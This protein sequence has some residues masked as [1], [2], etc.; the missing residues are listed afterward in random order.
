MMA[1]RPAA[2][3]PGMSISFVL[4]LTIAGLVLWW[5]TETRPRFQNGW[6]AQVGKIIFA[7]GMFVLTWH[8]A[9]DSLEF[10]E[11]RRIDR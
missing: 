4:F 1:C 3:L 6:L 5:I 7:C 11:P 9:G 2:T 8:L 10:F